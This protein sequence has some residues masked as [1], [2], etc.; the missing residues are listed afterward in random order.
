MS[1]LILAD[2]WWKYSEM[3]EKGTQNWFNLNLNLKAITRF[4]EGILFRIKLSHPYVEK[5]LRIF[6]FF[7]LSWMSKNNFTDTLDHD[8]LYLLFHHLKCFS[9]LLFMHFSFFT[10]SLLSKL[11][12]HLILEE[13]HQRQRLSLLCCSQSV[14]LQS[15]SDDCVF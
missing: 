7:H 1:V 3:C 10:K 11:V 8:E 14:P 9:Q 4:L 13:E 2:L 12:N 5:S 15:D 6:H